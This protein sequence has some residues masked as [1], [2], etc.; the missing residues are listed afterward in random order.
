V[1]IYDYHEDQ[2]PVPG[3]LER[4]EVPLTRT[5]LEVSDYVVSGVEN[6]A[7][8]HKGPGD[9]VSSLKDG[10]L[11]TQLYELSTNYSYAILLVEGNV[12]QELMERKMT[13]QQVLSS[14]A[15]SILKRSSDG[16]QGVISM[17]NVDTPWDAALFLKYCHDKVTAEEGLIRLP[18]LKA[19]KWKPEER[20][21]GI[22][23]GFPGVGEVRARNIMSHPQLNTLQKVMNA[24]IDELTQV[25]NIGLVTARKIYKL[26]RER[27][28]EKKCV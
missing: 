27:F 19:Q 11:H 10:R 20:A 3:L 6:V 25:E 8:E 2:G 13:R 5:E 7:V 26:T 14:L 18:V 16:K 12:T 24:E 22:L 1:I 28:G 21:I 15:G 9:Y 4:L 17:V 23:A